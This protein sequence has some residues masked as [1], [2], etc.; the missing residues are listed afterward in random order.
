MS[1]TGRTEKSKPAACAQ[2]GQPTRLDP[3]NPW[4]P[5]CSERCK[6]VD[7]G[8]WISG[9]YSIPAESETPPPDQ[10]EKFQ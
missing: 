1:Q 6:L 9:R 8:A 10:D 2:C 7:L 4:R 3:S 5:F